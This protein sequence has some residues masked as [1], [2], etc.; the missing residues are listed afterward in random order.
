MYRELVERLCRLIDKNGSDCWWE[1]P[2]EK[3]VGKKLMQELNVT[4][5]ERGNDIMDIWFDSGIS[6]S[7]VLP[8]GKADLYMEGMDQF[9]GWFQTSLLTSVALQ[10][11]APYK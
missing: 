5:L 9:T 3:I 8:E 6:W 1:L 4:K 7:T 11:S 2:V 10:N